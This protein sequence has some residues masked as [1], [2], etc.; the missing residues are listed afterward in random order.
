[1]RVAPSGRALLESPR[2]PID[3]SLRAP[4]P[5]RSNRDAEPQNASLEID[6]DVAFLV[7]GLVKAM[8]ARIR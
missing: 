4:N 2:F 1:M 5:M 6:F 7:S 3:T 8:V